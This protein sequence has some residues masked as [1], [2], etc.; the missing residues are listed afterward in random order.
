MSPL[1]HSK[2]FAA[3]MGTLERQPLEDRRLPVGRVRRRLAVRRR[4]GRN[5]D[6]L[7]E[8]RPRRRVPHGR[9]IISDA[10]FTV[11]KQ[12]ES[13]EEQ[14]EMVLLQ[15]KTLTADDP[16]FRAAIADAIKTVSAFPQVS[17]RALAA[18][19]RARPV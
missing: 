17:K 5:E 4:D 3:R 6:D 19:S 11:D 7:E 16:A 2:S 14:T 15:S 10:G 13:I 12:G 18:R 8:R 1:K 9:L